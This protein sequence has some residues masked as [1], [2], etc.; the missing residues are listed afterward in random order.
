MKS[1]KIAMETFGCER[2]GYCQDFDPSNAVKMAQHFATVPIGHCPASHLGQ[3]DERT[4]RSVSLSHIVDLGRMTQTVSAS[5]AELEARKA[6]E[7]GPDRPPVILQ[8][9]ERTKLTITNSQSTVVTEPVLEATST[10]RNG[11]S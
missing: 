5:D 6:M 10:K 8:I 4:R 2:C 3:N 1:I 7:F 9:G 11:P